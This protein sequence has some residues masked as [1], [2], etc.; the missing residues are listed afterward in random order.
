METFLIP[1]CL[2]FIE[3]FFFNLAPEFTEANLFAS[4]IK[5]KGLCTS[6]TADSI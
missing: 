2:P 5:L 3:G 4:L 6:Q 1:L